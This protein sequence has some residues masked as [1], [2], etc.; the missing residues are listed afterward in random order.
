MKLPD[1]KKLWGRAAR[2]CAFPGCK[3]KLTDDD[4]ENLSGEECHI[5]AS[6]ENGPR[7]DINFPEE[8]RNA[9]DNIILLCPNHH[10]V[11][12]AHTDIYTIAKLHQ[13]KKEHEDWVEKQLS[14]DDVQQQQEIE[15]Y[16]EFIQDFCDKIN[17]DNWDEWMQRL[18][19]SGQPSLCVR[20]YNR[21]IEIERI[22]FTCI[23]PSSYKEIKS[24]FINFRLVLNDLLTTFTSHAVQVGPPD[25]R[26]YQTKKYYKSN[27]GSY[28]RE[29]LVSDFNFH[30]ALVQDLALEL[31]R[32]A[33]YICDV[34][35]KSFDYKFR[36]NAGKLTITSGP[37]ADATFHTAIPEYSTSERQNP[38][39]YPGL[40]Q[41]M[42]IREKRDVHFGSGN[43][44]K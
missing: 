12:D 18:L 14:T 44:P 11:I 1:R 28:F 31:T 6:S 4:G 21:M 42:I 9:Y 3:T 20:D 7:G 5:V 29:D 17:I 32:A 19:L 38:N 34:I 35:R 39:M 2:M 16:A 30:V 25:Y 40:D 36:L 22:I 24:A 33:N 27:D 13:M 10:Q 15:F 41:F 23:W 8:K 43:C 37:Y 26:L